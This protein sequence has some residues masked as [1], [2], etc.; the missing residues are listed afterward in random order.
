MS[1][2]GSVVALIA[3]ISI[4]PAASQ[5]ALIGSGAHLPIPAS[6]PGTKISP[7]AIQ[8]EFA[9]RTPGVGGFSGGWST[10]VRPEWGGSYSVTGNPPDNQHSGD[11]EFDFTGMV[12]NHLPVGT[13]VYFGD[14]DRG[15]GLNETFTLRAF[16]DVAGTTPL[17]QWMDGPVGVRR[18]PTTGNNPPAGDLP[19]WSYNAATGEYTIDGST[20]SG[21]PNEAFMLQNNQAVVH[22]EVSKA[23]Q[24]YQMNLVA[25]LVPEPS[26]A[27]VVLLAL[28]TSG[29]VGRRTRLG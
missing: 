25:P 17:F 8:H 6:N 15:A 19:G 23:S 10:A 14:V 11:T 27:V 4:L 20:V 21:N 13:Y 18:S 24:P 1:A 26:S 22:L 9:T 29:L 5:A 16:A 7:I 2:T 12:N 28:S 3:S